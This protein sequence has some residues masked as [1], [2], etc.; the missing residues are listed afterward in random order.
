MGDIVGAILATAIS[1]TSP[2]RTADGRRLAAPGPRGLAGAMSKPLAVLKLGGAQARGGRLTDW[3]DAVLRHAGRLVV[4]PGGGPFADVVR[5][6]QAEIGIDD[7]A[8][9]EMA[10]LAVRQFGRAL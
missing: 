7:A 10:M 4:V 5:A 1:S 2:R 9:Q 8:A 6:S 3:L